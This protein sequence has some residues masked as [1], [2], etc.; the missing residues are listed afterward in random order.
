MSQMVCWILCSYLCSVSQ[1]LHVQYFLSRAYGTLQQTSMQSLNAG[2]RSQVAMNEGPKVDPPVTKTWARLEGLVR[3][4][5]PQ[6]TYVQYT[7]V[8]S[9][10]EVSLV[11]QY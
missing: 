7:V 9:V 5:T 6:S 8:D 3:S 10:H 1:S 11:V 4:W 2:S